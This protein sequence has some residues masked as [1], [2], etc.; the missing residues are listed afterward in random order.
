MG[1]A[2][3]G[4][5]IHDTDGSVAAY[6]CGSAHADVYERRGGDRVRKTGNALFLPVLFPAQYYARTGGN[7]TWNRKKRAADGDPFNI[8]LPV[9]DHLD[10][11]CAPT[12]CHD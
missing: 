1:H 10:P 12:V 4:F 11:V 9:S 8:S 7:G 2:C 5:C 3:D 6:F